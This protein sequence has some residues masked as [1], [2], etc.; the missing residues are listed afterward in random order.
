VAA[1]AQLH[2]FLQQGLP[3]YGT[4]RN[5]PDTDASSGLSPYLHWGHLSAHEV[6]DAVIAREGWLGD[7]PRRATGA[8]EGWWGVSA[9]AEAFLDQLITWRELGYNLT[10]KRDDYDRFESLPSW[11]LTTLEAHEADHREVAY[12]LG[13]LEHGRTHIPL[14]RGAAVTGGRKRAQPAHALGQDP[15]VSRRRRATVWR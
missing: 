5:H 12:D 14:E 6:F 2:Q 9:S 10:S 4:A 7:T 13:A 8:R 3:N 15:V 1:R 11:A